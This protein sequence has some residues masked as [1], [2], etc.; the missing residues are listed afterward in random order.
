MHMFL[1]YSARARLNVSFTASRARFWYVIVR[2]TLHC[3]LCLLTASRARFCYRA[4]LCI[5]HRVPHRRAGFCL[6]YYDI[7][8]WCM[9][10]W[11]GWHLIWSVCSPR[12]VLEGRVLLPRPSLE[13]RVL[14]YVRYGVL[15]ICIFDIWLW[16]CYRVPQRGPG[17]VIC[18][19]VWSDSVFCMFCSA[20]ES[21]S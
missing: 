5:V 6:W 11:P 1:H 8:I 19:R 17:S 10:W 16:F 9:G 13:G 15:I 14:I 7:M 20:Y 21:D 4:P 12:P 18:I 2:I 3:L